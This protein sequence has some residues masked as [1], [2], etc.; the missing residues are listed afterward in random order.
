VSF[1]EEDDDVNWNYGITC[2]SINDFKE[3]EAA[4]IKIKNER[5]IFTLAHCYKMG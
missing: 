4:F 3:A 5:Y 1:F 2:A